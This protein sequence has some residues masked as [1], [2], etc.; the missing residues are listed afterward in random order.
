MRSVVS[1]LLL[2]LATTSAFA[3]EIPEPGSLSLIGVAVA[4]G[5]FVALRK[6]K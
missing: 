5:L 4:A 6:K 2:A 1:S 3:A